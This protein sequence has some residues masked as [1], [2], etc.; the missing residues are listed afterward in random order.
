M[1]NKPAPAPT[2][3]GQ[4]GAIP[5]GTRWSDLIA[6][7]SV[8]G[9]LLPEA[10]AYSG[11]ANLPP[12]AGIIALL[13]GLLCYGLI[14]K[15]PFAIASATSSSAVV[16]AAATAQLASGNVALQLLLGAGLLM[17]TGLLFLVAALARL[18]NM[19]DFIAKPVLRGVTF[20]LVI[21]IILRQ[22]PNIVQIHPR[23]DDVP[24]F[25][26]ELLSQ[27]PSW[28][29]VGLLT[30]G[31][32][33][34][35]LTA[36][37]RIRRLPAALLVI[38]LGIGAN[39]W[40]NLTGYG[41]PQ[42]GTVTIHW[43]IPSL[44]GLSRV[45]WSRLGELAVAMLL[46]LYAESYSSIRYFAL[47]HGQDTTPNRDLAALGVANLI[48]GLMHGMPIGAGYSASSANEAAGAQSRLAGLIAAA[49]VLLIVLTLLPAIALTPEPVLAAI[50]IHA[51]GHT[52][53][54]SMFRPYFRW[55]RDRLIVVGAVLAVLLLGVLDGLLAAIA[56]S[57]A[58]TLR[59][60]AEPNL[61][62]LGRV[63][64]GHDFAGR[65]VHPDAQPV[66]GI[67]I[68]RPEEPLFFA[69]VERMLT[70]VRQLMLEDPTTIHTVVL[71]L[72]ESPDLDGTSIEAMSE[73]ADFVAQGQRQL[74]LAR[75]HDEALA[76][77]ARAAPP[78]LPLTT[79]YLSVDDAVTAA[80]QHR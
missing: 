6:G 59:Q 54:P 10:V 61:S 49:V 19:S 47:K 48:A 74:L 1:I 2:P 24:R 4:S 53:Q 23:H 52:L 45:Q 3:P 58:L 33:L 64:N 12:Q 63:G 26:F 43:D 67:L 66:P 55:R 80:L 39:A 65:A 16:L 13:I 76:V 21:V 70:R 9:L 15:S 5:T 79:R 25:A 22:L 14:G 32:A 50:V 51:V 77:L 62:V 75:A 7:L 30:G 72:E 40:L 46:I 41:V 71:S 69:N 57:L 18:G 68:V 34:A 56:A 11:I 42:V 36:L 37:G 27:F 8:A 78:A 17:L 31:I 60:F 44:P 29:L 73:F 20:G 28:N 35:L 38:A